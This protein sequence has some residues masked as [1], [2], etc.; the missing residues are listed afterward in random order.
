VAGVWG[1]QTARG[2]TYSN[3]HTQCECHC[4]MPDCSCKQ[5]AL[6]NDAPDYNSNFRKSCE[7]RRPGSRVCCQCPHRTANCARTANHTCCLKATCACQTATPLKWPLSKMHDTRMRCLTGH[8]GFVVAG[9]LGTQKLR[10]SC[11]RPTLSQWC[12]IRNFYKVFECHLCLPD[13]N[14]TQ[15]TRSARCMR[16]E[17]PVCKTHRGW[18]WLG[19]GVPKHWVG[20]ALSTPCTWRPIAPQQR[21]IHVVSRPP[22]LVS[23]Q[24]RPSDC[25]ARCM[26]LAC[27]VCKTHRGW[28]WLG[29]GQPNGQRR[30]IQQ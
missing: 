21:F 28:W 29:M 10:R 5:P 6:P 30:H 2:A 8:N 22:V 17:C 15:V 14:C 24:L 26:R 20:R 7:S 12:Y 18:W 4:S 1:S 13:C 9:V 25:S 11:T 16:L 19:W 27:T 23:S 3:N